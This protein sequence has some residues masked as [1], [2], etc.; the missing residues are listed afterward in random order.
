MSRLRSQQANGQ[1][2]GSRLVH[3][4]AQASVTTLSVP[5]TETQVLLRSLRPGT[6]ETLY[7]VI[8]DSKKAS[9]GHDVGPDNR[10]LHP[11]GTST[12]VPS[13]SIVT[14]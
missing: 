1:N 12:S 10:R 6:G 2:I 9:D 11:G 8:D 3:Y 7:V 5:E 14:T 4:S 13:W